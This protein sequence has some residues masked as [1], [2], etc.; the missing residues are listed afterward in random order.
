MTQRCLGVVLWIFLLCHSPFFTQ[1]ALALEVP[2]EC[3]KSFLQ[4]KIHPGKD[5]EISCNLQA[6]DMSNFDCSRFCSD[7]CKPVSNTT[8]QPPIELK[9]SALYPGLTDDER[10]FVDRDPKMA[11]KAYWLSWRAEAACESVYL[12]SDTNDESDACRH[13]VWAALLNAEY[14]QTRSSELLDAHEN[15]P[16]EP[17]DEKAMDLANNR[18]GLIASTDLIKSKKNR[19]V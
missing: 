18:R 5:C 10:K 9:L 8:S 6:A 12:Y 11:L 1:V 14:G 16:E 7:Y 2:K 15:N 17:N 3:K 4:A 13:F 19:G